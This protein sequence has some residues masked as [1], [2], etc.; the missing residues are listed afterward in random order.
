MC[1]AA[2]LAAMPMRVGSIAC[3]GWSN[4]SQRTILGIVLLEV[5]RKMTGLSQELSTRLNAWLERAERIQGQKPR[6]K[7]KAYAL[8]APEVE[9]IGKGRTRT[10]YEFGVKAAW[11]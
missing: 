5:R 7:N 4:V 3:A 1:C 2:W 10:P 9:C 6:Y 11:P 8:Q